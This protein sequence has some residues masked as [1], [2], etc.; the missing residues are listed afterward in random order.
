MST[1]FLDWTIQDLKGLRKKLEQMYLN[2]VRQ[3]TFKDQTLI[4]TSDDGIKRRITDV[5][6][7]INEQE[8]AC[9][10]GDNG[11]GRNKKKILFTTRNKGFN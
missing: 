2:G 11:G 4:F 7:A 3:S 10:T 8:E 9:G 5:T 6:T 1:L